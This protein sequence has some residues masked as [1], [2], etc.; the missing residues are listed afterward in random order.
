ML[1]WLRVTLAMLLGRIPL[2]D[3]IAAFLK[4]LGVQ[5][6]G[7]CER[8]RAAV[9]AWHAGLLNA[10]RRSPKGS[11]RVVVVRGRDGRMHRFAERQP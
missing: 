9:N 2:G 4:R 6:C 8:R 3:R 1:R 5:P 11:V 7:G 10:G